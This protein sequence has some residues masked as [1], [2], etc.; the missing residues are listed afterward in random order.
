MRKEI[1]D[2]KKID[3]E[4]STEESAEGTRTQ[5]MKEM[6]NKSK[7]KETSTE[8]N[9]EIKRIVSKDYEQVKVSQN[10]DSPDPRVGGTTIMFDSRLDEISSKSNTRDIDA[11]MKTK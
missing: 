3:N 9:V 7:T 1:E 2:Q 5:R 4:N 10:A 11:F 8:G 6:L